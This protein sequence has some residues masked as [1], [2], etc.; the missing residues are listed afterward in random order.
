MFQL[1]GYLEY[2]SKKKRGL[3]KSD[4][5]SNCAISGW[6]GWIGY[7]QARVGIDHL[8]VTTIGDLTRRG[9]AAGGR[10]QGWR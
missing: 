2:M 8:T 10:W 9:I 5:I 4:V 7:L 6:M 1:A 3:V